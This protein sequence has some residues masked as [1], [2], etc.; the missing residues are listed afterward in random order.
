MV[1]VASEKVKDLTHLCGHWKPPPPQIITE[2]DVERK[3]VSKGQI[4]SSNESG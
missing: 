1:S 3:A 4:L 2:I